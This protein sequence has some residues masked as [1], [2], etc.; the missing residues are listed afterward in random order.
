VIL[1]ITTIEIKMQQLP[2]KMQLKSSFSRNLV[3]RLFFFSLL[4]HAVFSLASL[5]LTVSYRGGFATIRSS[6]LYVV[7]MSI[8]LQGAVALLALKWRLHVDSPHS[9][10]FQYKLILLV[11]AVIIGVVGYYLIGERFLMLSGNDRSIFDCTLSI[12]CSIASTLVFVTENERK[13]GNQICLP[14]SPP[15]I[16]QHIKSLIISDGYSWIRINVAIGVIIILL[17]QT[18]TYIFFHKHCTK[19]QIC[20]IEDKMNSNFFLSLYLSI[21]LSTLVLCSLEIL[22]SL[23]VLILSYPLDFSKLES[24]AKLMISNTN[25]ESGDVFLTNAL[26]I[27]GLQ[28]GTVFDFLLLMPFFGWSV[29]YIWSTVF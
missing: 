8:L 18:G 2:E 6:I 3:R 25:S 20:E 15:S 22:H 13:R 7:V 10:S 5:L 1:K 17:K 27:G 24:Q 16:F 28:S 19:N 9:F 21:L 23:L 29:F 4:S 14:P 11:L 12:T 26:V